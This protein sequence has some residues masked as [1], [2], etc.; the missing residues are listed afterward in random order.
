MNKKKEKLKAE[1][2]YWCTCSD[3]PDI[4]LGCAIDKLVNKVMGDIGTT[5]L[6]NRTYNI[7][8]Q[9]DKR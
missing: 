8:K 3:N 1:P 6:K 4:C 9:S 7:R 2:A 5:F